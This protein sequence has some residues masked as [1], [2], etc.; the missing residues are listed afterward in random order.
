MNL[1]ENIYRIRQIMLLEQRPDNLMPFQPEIFG[2]NPKKPETTKGALEKQ[3]EFFRSIDPH[4]V[5]M[6]LGIATAFIPVIG[7]FISAGI[8]LADAH[9]YY[10]EGD[11]TSGNIAVAFS[12]IPV[13][14]AGLAK[15]PGIK[16]L[17]ARGMA[18]LASKLKTNKPLTPTEI[19]AVNEIKQNS[20]VIT[21]TLNQAS[22]RL[23]GVAAEVKALKGPYIEKFG[24]DKYEELLSQFITGNMDKVTFINTLKGGQVAWGP[25]VG[26]TAKYGVKFSQQEINQI[27]YL[28]DKIKSWDTLTIYID[29]PFGK[30]VKH[31]IKKARLSQLDPSIRFKHKNT[32]M[33]ADSRNKEIVVI[34]DNVE[35][36]S[37]GYIKDVLVHEVGHLKDP[38]VVKSTKLINSY[39]NLGNIADEQLRFDTYYHH[40][41][42]RVAN[43][44]QSLQIF[45]NHVK[46]AQRTMSKQQ[47]LNALDNIIQYTGGNTI[48]F[49][50]DALKLLYGE[51]PPSYLVNFYQEMAKNPEYPK[52]MAKL[53]RQA[54]DL[55]SQIKIAM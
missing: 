4:T 23:S 3:Q 1:E 15:I 30:G 37:E 19:I 18:A 26:F 14:G 20:K 36:Q 6:V 7:P 48:E 46:N 22:Q 12:L 43:T 13:V 47:I 8:G 2:Y 28:G 35:G 39:D 50:D 44:A 10:K 55:K 41:F 49:S 9:L 38:A 24:L 5:T 40:P 11:E 25:W 54:M 27:A 51:N 45:A 32:M 16:Q 53:R 33:W 34:L 52:I 31:T 29:T 17:G 42:E 21:T